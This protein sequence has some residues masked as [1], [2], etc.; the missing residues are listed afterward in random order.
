MQRPHSPDVRLAPRAVESPNLRLV[1]SRFAPLA[2]ICKEAPSGFSKSPESVF[3]ARIAR[4]QVA[5]RSCNLR[6]GH[7]D[8][9]PIKKAN[10][11]LRPTVGGGDPGGM[12]Q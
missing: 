10:R 1:Y 6:C 5:T 9:G 8:R 7:G 3:V 2:P 12:Q 11:Q 4:R